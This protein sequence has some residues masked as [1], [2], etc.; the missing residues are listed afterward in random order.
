M[1]FISPFCLDSSIPPDLIT[2]CDVLVST[3]ATAHV[4]AAE[5]LLH[6]QQP[7]VAGQAFFIADFDDNVMDLNMQAMRQTDLSIVLMPALAGIRAVLALRPPRSAVALGQ[8][9]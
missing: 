8:Q 9:S 3:A 5:A 2:L 4:L 1:T 6:P 7:E